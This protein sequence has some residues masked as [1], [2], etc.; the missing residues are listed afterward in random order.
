M[1]ATN[2]FTV[3]PFGDFYMSV[4]DELNKI[5]EDIRECHI[6]PEIDSEKTLLLTQ[7][8]NPKSDVFIVS[9]SLA[10]DMARLS[11][12][13]FFKTSGEPGIS[14]RNL[15]KFL[16]KFNR[17]IYPPQE[18]RLPKDATIRKCE[19]DYIP[20]Y[21]TPIAQCY[22]G[23]KENGECRTPKKSEILNCI[24]QRFVIKEL[25]SIKPNYSSLWENQA[26]TISLNIY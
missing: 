17:T 24:S 10:E 9:Q 11:G 20:A 15:E 19:P 1:K 6:C 8:V 3:E 13:R 25:E 16:N 2:N 23:R 22:P 26:E 4:I 14:G 5:Y 12:V 7:A 18:V 21:T